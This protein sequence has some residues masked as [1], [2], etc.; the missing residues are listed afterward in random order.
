V[1]APR[2]HAFLRA[3]RPVIGT[4]FETG[5]DVLEL[6]HAR[7]REKQGRV[8]AG[9]EGARWHHAVLVLAEKVEKART[10]V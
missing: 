2:P 5:E 9:H 4:L 3:C 8:V 7:I 10:D 6:H 1:L